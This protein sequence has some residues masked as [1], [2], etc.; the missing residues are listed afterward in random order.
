MFRPIL[1]VVAGFVLWSVLW[2]LLNQVLAASGLLPA[3]GQ[4]VTATVP[5]VALLLASIVISLLAGYVTARIAATQAFKAALV[6]GALLLV[7][8][9][10]VEAANWQLLPPWYHI[11]F[12]VCLVP[13]CI[14]GA[15][16]LAPRG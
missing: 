11:S 14:A 10:A 6:L 8:G 13:A 2:L 3:P 4:P 16:L 15:R 7:T 9:I 12:L 1:A 5:L